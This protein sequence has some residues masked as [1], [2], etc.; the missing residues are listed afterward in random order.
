MRRRCEPGW[1]MRG[2]RRAGGWWWWGG[3]SKGRRGLLLRS[4]WAMT[5]KQRVGRRVLMEGAKM[6]WESRRVV[7][8]GKRRRRRAPLRRA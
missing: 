4:G 8:S 6:R 1:S 5:Q 3:R 2:R 7:R